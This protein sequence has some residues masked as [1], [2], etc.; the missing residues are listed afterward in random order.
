MRP[1]YQYQPFTTADNIRL[2]SILPAP[3]HSS[4]VQ[5]N[6]TAYSLGQPEGGYEALSYT[7]GDA[8]DRAVLFIGD[9]QLQVTRNCLDALLHLRREDTV[10]VV[11]IGAIC[12]NQEDEGERSEQV[13]IM[14]RIYREADQVI[15]YLGDETEGIRY[16][17]AELELADQVFQVYQKW[18]RSH[19]SPLIINELD[20][21]LAR[22]YFTRVWVVQEIQLARRVKIMC[23]SR[24]A[25]REALIKCAFG[26][27]Q[28]LLA[29]RYMP[30]VMNLNL[31]STL[32]F[33]FQ[34]SALALWQFL[35]ITRNCYSSDPRDRIFALKAFL[36]SG[37]NEI[38]YLVDYEQS[39]E[40]TFTAVTEYLLSAVGLWV[41]LAI[42]H[43]HAPSQQD[44]P[45]WVPD[46]SLHS[47]PNN[48]W[49]AGEIPQVGR[50]F[51]DAVEE[52]SPEFTILEIRSPQSSSAQLHRILSVN[53]VRI[54]RISSMC[55]SLQPRNKQP[56]VVDDQVEE[57]LDSSTLPW[58]R[59]YELFEFGM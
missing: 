21:L 14:D 56:R 33:E 30:A 53:G 41:L 57:P 24:T 5:C 16:L 49:Y 34:S 4:I 17:F 18:S 10:R 2:V 58:Q 50:A 13:K 7:W 8:A 45:S 46:W 19:P 25:S 31:A 55:E 1:S 54:G 39:I 27:S 52:N 15:A 22:P 51:D 38:D 40:S 3:R 26:Y 23:G 9:A 6:L 47:R 37:G 42:S 36:P 12:I 59:L 29:A 28:T 43:P 44:L 32:D 35:A 48:V 11:W 20:N